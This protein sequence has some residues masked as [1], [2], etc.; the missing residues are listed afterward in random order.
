[1]GK[2]RGTLV[3]KGS[4]TPVHLG[5]VVAWLE[6]ESD[7]QNVKRFCGQNFIPESRMARGSDLLSTFCKIVPSRDNSMGSK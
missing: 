2:G 3:F 6:M 1:M 7:R 5:F 4:D